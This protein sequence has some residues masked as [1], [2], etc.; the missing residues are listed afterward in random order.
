[1]LSLD[2]QTVLQ[3]LS[4]SVAQNLADP[5]GFLTAVLCFSLFDTHTVCLRSDYVALNSLLTGR[6]LLFLKFFLQLG[7]FGVVD[8]FLRHLFFPSY[9]TV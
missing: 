7:V 4:C 6:A 8:N 1:M 2:L 3:P 5:L 9:I